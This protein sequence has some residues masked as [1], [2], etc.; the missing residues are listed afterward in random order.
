MKNFRNSFLISI[1][2]LFVSF[3]YSWAQLQVDSVS[4]EELKKVINLIQ[5]K[6]L[7]DG[8]CEWRGLDSDT[9]LPENKKIILDKYTT[10]YQIH[11]YPG[12]SFATYKFFTF[13]EIEDEI[14]PKYSVQLIEFPYPIV[15]GEGSDT[16]RGI[17]ITDH[18]SN[19]WFV[20][21]TNELHSSSGY[22]AGF[23]STGVTYKLKFT[24]NKNF[25]PKFV[26]K[27]FD[28]D[29][30][31]DL[32]TFNNYEF[33]FFP[34]NKILNQDPQPIENLDKFGLWD[35]TLELIN[36]EKKNGCKRPFNESIKS[37]L[38]FV[39][40]PISYELIDV[41]QTFAQVIDY[42]KFR[43]INGYNDY[44]GT[45]GNSLKL[46]V[47]DNDVNQEKLFDFGL[48]RSWNFQRYKQEIP[49][50]ILSLNG[51]SCNKSSYRNCF[52]SLVYQ[53]GEFVSLLDN[54]K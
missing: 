31:P 39:D 35:I 34:K 5:N 48:V 30:I 44:S 37:T 28:V 33:R 6:G 25:L 50:L 2:L 11:C 23:I 24:P 43:C 17:G 7:D 36:Y 19:A 22:R 27:E 49:L 20:S 26:L 46:V 29:S 12:A 8:M 51:L 38:G 15:S 42:S 3:A 18:L 9:F 14:H 41:R 16:L 21:Q 40:N 10:I 53:E 32:T 4:R 13:L 52:V 54:Y 45:E 47:F 1:L